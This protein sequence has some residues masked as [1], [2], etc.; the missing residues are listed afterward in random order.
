[1]GIRW[2]DA[3]PLVLEREQAAMAEHAPEMAWI[4]EGAGRWEGF[5]PEWPFARERPEPGLTRL[6]DG[7]QLHLR[8]EYLQAFPAVA[9]VLRPLG[10]IPPRERRL[11][12][13]W[14]VNGDGSLCMLAADILW[15]PDDTAADLVIK[16]SGWLI[17]YRL[18]ERGL[19]EAM[20]ET[21]LYDDAGS[22]GTTN[23]NSWSAP[24]QRRRRPT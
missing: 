3:E 20:S 11:Q 12:H 13:D 4:D 18:K 8:V 9:P 15:R 2:Y 6:L 17:E 10:P 22:G 21:G 5:A 23:S 1:V 14:H 16:A 19:I 7:E 24:A